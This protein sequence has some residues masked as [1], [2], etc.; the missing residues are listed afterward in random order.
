[1]SCF[2]SGA[3]VSVRYYSGGF[4]RTVNFNEN[5]YKYMQYLT[6]ESGI[7]AAYERGSD[8][9]AAWCYLHSDHLGS[10]VLA[11]DAQGQ[12]CE[13]RRY[14]AWG[15]PDSGAWH[16]SRGYTGHE[17]LPE[18]GLI[19]MNGRMYDPILGR[20]LSPDPYVVDAGF[21]QDFNRYSYARNNPLVYVDPS[22][23]SFIVAA[24]IVGVI[25]GAYI[26]GS[27][28]NNTLNPTK[29]RWGGSTWVSM[30]IGGVIGALGGWGFAAAA[31]AVAGTS[32]FSSFGASGTVAAYSFVGTATGG[33][34]GY[35]A[36][37][38]SALYTS[39]GDFGY[40]NHMGGIMSGVGAQIGSVAGMAGGG[41]A[42]YGTKLAK[43]GAEVATAAAARQTAKEAAKEGT[44]GFRSFSAFKR[45]MGSAGEGQAWHHIVEQTPGNV[46]RFGAETIHNTGNLM[47]LPHGAGSIHNRL[48]GHY[49][50]IQDFTNGQTVRQWLSTQSYQAQYD[51]GIKM[52]KQF[53]W[54]P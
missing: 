52:L 28:A 35:G 54:M 40:A 16:F 6:A 18:F 12:P 43:A 5:Y 14:D 48:S 34:V 13:Q 23:E 50:S 37:F 1:M 29:W 36:G 15:Q 32:F 22:G 51:Y 53:G 19:N 30:G 39:G 8:G 2:R 10:L 46:S 24:I 3:L 41:W 27:V 21:S 9:A 26:G 47:K 49:S 31:P 38:G 42:A 45:A 20:M 11:T 25:V 4:E 7:F 44:Q 17:H 33:A